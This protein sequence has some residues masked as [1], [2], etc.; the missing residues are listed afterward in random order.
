M[1][2]DLIEAHAAVLMLQETMAE[3]VGEMAGGLREKRIFTNLAMILPGLY[4]SMI[5]ECVYEGFNERMSIYF[6]QRHR[7]VE[8]I[9]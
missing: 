2:K 1:M 7:C 5:T 8:C 9:F 6:Y 4:T 3:S